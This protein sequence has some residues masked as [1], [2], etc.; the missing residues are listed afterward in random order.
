MKTLF[1]LVLLAAQA[2][3]A[4]GEQPVAGTWAFKQGGKIVS[5][6]KLNADGTYYEANYRTIPEDGSIVLNNVYDLIPPSFLWKQDGS[7]V[8]FHYRGDDTPVAAYTLSGG[9]LIDMADG[10]VAVRVPVAEIPRS[11]LRPVLMVKKG[12]TLTLQGKETVA[13][14]DLCQY[15]FGSVPDLQPADPAKPLMQI[16]EATTAPPGPEEML[17]IKTP[18]HFDYESSKPLL[19]VR[20]VHDI[21]LAPDGKGVILYLDDRDAQTYYELTKKYE[22]GYLIMIATDAVGQVM[23]ITGEVRDG[24]MSFEGPGKDEVAK[25]LRQRFRLG[26]FK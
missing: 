8:V 1:I 19:T 6:R 7:A 12:E 3:I 16:Y 17:G 22:K 14:V 15:S 10:L 13:T 9:K 26:E 5:Y 2:A 4:A 23:H 20:D 21:L 24:Y 25:Y 11:L 18:L